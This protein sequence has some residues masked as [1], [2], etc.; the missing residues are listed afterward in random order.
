V[1]GVEA[2]VRDANVVAKLADGGTVAITV[3]KAKA[4]DVMAAIVALSPHAATGFDPEREAQFAR[5]PR[6]LR[7]AG[8]A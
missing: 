2:P 1:S 4:A 8:A 6:S 7:G 5:D 3:A